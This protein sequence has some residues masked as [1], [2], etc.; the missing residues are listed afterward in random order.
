MAG[1]FHWLP[2]SVAM[3]GGSW[4]MGAG[5][6]AALC[7]VW[8]LR[9]GAFALLSAWLREKLGRHGST[10]GAT[11]LL[12]LALPASWV[13][14]EFLSTTVFTKASLVFFTNLAYTQ[15]A[16]P[17]LIQPAAW[18]G[19]YGVSFLLVMGNVALALAWPMRSWRPIVLAG[20]V[21]VASAAA[22]QARLRWAAPGGEGVRVAVLQPDIGPFKELNKELGDLLARRHMRLAEEARRL[23]PDLV[24]WSESAIPWELKKDDDLVPA[25]LERLLPLRP[26][27]LLGSLSR[28]PGAS[29]NALH[30]TAFLLLGDGR[31]VGRCHKTR[32]VLFAEVQ[33]RFMSAFG[34][35]DAWLESEKRHLVAGTS[36]ETIASPLGRI[37]V[38]MC[39]ENLY[40]DMCC[41]LVERDAEFLVNLAN[42]VWVGSRWGM[43]QHSTGHVLRAVEA[44]R[45][46][47]VANN[48]G[49]SCLIDGY[50]RILARAGLHEQTCL[51]G[52]VRGRSGRTFYV[53]HGDLFAWLCAV[54]LAAGLAFIGL[55]SGPGPGDSGPGRR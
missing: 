10:W 17:A 12:L 18:A 15:W 38:T 26:C 49:I 54:G 48:S 50:G 37:G 11:A 23:K 41:A 8:G 14:L 6:L 52:E 47:V 25:V 4:A 5:M 43:H 3:L 34:A 22:G 32:P 35:E 45:D 31:V 30:G 1:T 13:A 42:G 46:M 29:E 21:I 2:K 9:F 44:G 39:N 40:G 24:V 28:V 36:Q 20:A 27:H 33:A 19:V 51:G 53:R 55:R 16:H 7:L